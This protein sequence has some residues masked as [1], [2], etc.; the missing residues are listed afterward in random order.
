MFWGRRD[1]DAIRQGQDTVPD[2]LLKAIVQFKN[3]LADRGIDFTVPFPPTP[4]FEGHPSPTV[5]KRL[6]NI[7]PAGPKCCSSWLTMTSKSS[8]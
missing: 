1:I 4:F 5:L 8:T 3:D 2:G 6:M 7:I